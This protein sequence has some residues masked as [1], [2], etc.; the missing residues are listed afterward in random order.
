MQRTTGTISVF[1]PQL[2]QRHSVHHTRA[3]VLLN[4]A[5]LLARYHA[6]RM[7]PV[8]TAQDTGRKDRPSFHS[9]NQ[10]SMKKENSHPY[11]PRP[12]FSSARKEESK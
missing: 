2:F 12:R 8:R 10:L 6:S 11:F 3:V 7:D 9:I 5:V 4:K 1:F